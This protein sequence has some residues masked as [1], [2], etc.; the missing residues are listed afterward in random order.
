MF[1]PVRMSL[2]DVAVAEDEAFSLLE[3]MDDFGSFQPCGPGEAGRKEEGLSPGVAVDTEEA[4]RLREML[5]RVERVAA[6]FA[7]VE[8]GENVRGETSVPE[9]AW[10]RDEAGRELDAVE[11]ALARLEKEREEIHRDACAQEDLSE[12][13]QA[14]EEAGIP[15]G[16]FAGLTRFHAVAGVIEQPPDAPPFSAAVSRLS[17]AVHVRSVSARRAAVVLLAHPSSRE[18]A[19]EVLRAY[20]FRRVEIPPVYHLSFEDAEEEV[21]MGFWRLRDRET[22]SAR[23]L[24][25]LA[26][27]KAPFVRDL[28]RSLSRLLNMYDAAVLFTSTPSVAVLSGFVPSGE[29]PLLA[30]RLEERFGTAY[31]MRE[32]HVAE[33]PSPRRE[34]LTVPVKLG[35]PSSLAPFESLVKMYGCP[36]YE[37]FDP[38]LFFAL[39]FLL[40]FGMMFGDVG[41][42]LVLAAGGLAVWKIGRARD[43]G[44]LF[45]YAGCAGAFF[46][47]LYG[48]VF[49]MEDVLIRH[50]WISPMRRVEYILGVSVGIGAAMILLGL[51]L[52]IANALR[53][54]DFREAFFGEYGFMSIL[55]Y[56]GGLV[57]FLLLARGVEISVPL[58]ICLL[59]LPLAVMTAGEVYLA[60][61][62][63]KGD[64]AELSFK[65]VMVSL[66]YVTN[67]ISFIRVGAFALNHAALSWA[68]VMIAGMAGNMVLRADVLVAGNVVVIL[69]EAM[70]VTI[71]CLRLEY[72]EFFSK[73]FKGTGVPFRRFSLERAVE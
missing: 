19:E 48:S 51:G 7:A 38:T 32:T 67:T 12:V 46:G 24:L 14:L 72:Y 20:R 61:R 30:E 33:L 53:R 3:V 29:V 6:H 57:M 2:V 13:L 28:R 23:K 22:E 1:I 71:Q 10:D 36:A 60:V 59:L 55:F 52:N 11:K 16:E 45:V 4:E 58:G 5:T 47:V 43:F 34:H 31:Y 62:E 49:G 41:H 64:L 9:A 69:L 21:E 65:P 27:E 15:P 68:L 63:G 39:S 56:L 18:E 54:R 73:F 66:D 42:G 25:S 8:G 40:M 37:E 35:N 44:L 70:V 50:L 26:K 17:C